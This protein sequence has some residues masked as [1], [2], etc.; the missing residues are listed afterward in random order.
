MNPVV[1]YIALSNLI[2]IHSNLTTNEIAAT[3]LFCTIQNESVVVQDSYT[4][5]NMA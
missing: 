1:I 2:A 5:K 4:E 3:N